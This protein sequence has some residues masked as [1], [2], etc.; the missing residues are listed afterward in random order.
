MTE[1]MFPVGCGTALA[2]PPVGVQGP[3]DDSVAGENRKKLLVVAVAAGLL[4]AVIAAYFLMKSGGSSNASSGLV[5]SARHFVPGATA[6]KAP[7]TGSKPVTLPRQV[8]APEGRNPFKPL[9][10]VPAAAPAGTAASS[11]TAPQSPTTAPVTTTSTSS[12]TGSSTGSS[13]GSS[14]S[15]TQA[16]HAVWIQ[17]KSLSTTE[18]TFLVGYSNGKTLR[19]IRYSGV[20]A[21]ASGKTTVFATNFQ[22]FSIRSGVATLRFGDGSTFALDMEHNYMVVG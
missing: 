14:S 22:L 6:G 9:Y 3:D 21:P 8:A 17:L 5:P 16:Y 2:E 11:A 7:S 10:V 19:A 20:K 18:A 1:Q 13:S 12:S 15:T 4:V